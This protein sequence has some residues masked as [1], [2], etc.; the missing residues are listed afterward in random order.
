[1]LPGVGPGEVVGWIADLVT[2]DGSVA[3]CGQ[4]IAPLGVIIAILSL[5]TGIDCVGG[6]GVDR[7]GQDITGIV[8]GP[9]GGGVGFLVI[10][11]DQ[12]IG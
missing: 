10:L 4:Q 6:I 2:D 12:L 8:V 7:P 3:V 9:E 5:S 1:M 11:P